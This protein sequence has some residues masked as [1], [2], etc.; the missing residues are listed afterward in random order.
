MDN[1]TKIFKNSKS[2]QNN[3]K[4]LLDNMGIVHFNKKYDE[5]TYQDQLYIRNRITNV[6]EVNTE[7]NNEKGIDNRYLKI[8][9]WDFYCL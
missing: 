7:I 9:D 4:T 1:N 2:I 5:L 3:L 8:K 6:L